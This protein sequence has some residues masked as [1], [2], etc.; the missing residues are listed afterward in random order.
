MLFTEPFFLFY[1]LPVALLLF[2]LSLGRDPRLFPKTAQLCLFVLTLVFYGFKEPWWLAPFLVCL[3]LDY[4]WARWLEIC[5]GRGLRRWIVFCSLGQNLLLLFYFKYWWFYSKDSSFLPLITQNGL[6][7]ALPPGIS[8]YTFESLSFVFDVYRK[9]VTAPKNPMRYF[10]FLGM[11]PRFVAGPIVR[12]TDISRQYDHYKGMHLE[13]G[14]YLFSVGLFYKLVFADSFKYFVQYAFD[15][16][17]PISVAGAWVGVFAYCLQL[18]FDFHGYS[19]MAVGLGYCLGFKFPMNFNRPFLSTSLGDFWRRWHITLGMWIR[20]Y[21]FLPI[22]LYAQRK[23]RWLVYPALVLTTV[24]F[25]I[26]HGPGWKFVIMG[27]WFGLVLCLEAA[28]KLPRRLPAF[29]GWLMTFFVVMTG[30][31]FLRGKDLDQ[32]LLVIRTMFGMGVQEFGTFTFEPFFAN[33]QATFI[34]LIGLIYCFRFE[35]ELNILEYSPKRKWVQ[36]SFAF[37]C[38]LVSLLI[39]YSSK[40]I[41]FLYFQF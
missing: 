28:L 31:V 18:Y 24:L 29:L 41:P 27:L 19:I 7:L 40:V 39:G 8:F 17:N 34:C 37:C 16:F 14:L 20:D 36:A 38:V 33:P 3:V 6:P 4:F 13:K 9:K 32:S 1:Y 21:V 30:W 26:W 25:G 23:A 10:S 15:I 12:Y 11:F 5:Q 35:G 2:R 22:A